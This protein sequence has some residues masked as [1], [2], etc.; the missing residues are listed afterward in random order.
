MRKACWWKYLSMIM[1]MVLMISMM[2]VQGVFAS[3]EGQGKTV[4]SSFDEMPVLE[5]TSFAQGTK[6]EDLGLPKEVTAYDEAGTSI[7][8]TD[9]VWK[10][11]AKSDETNSDVKAE[12]YSESLP[13]G[14]YVFLL[15]LGK[16]YKLADGVE[17]P[18]FYI[19]ITEPE[20]E[21]A[22]TAPETAETT[23]ETAETAPETAE[24]TP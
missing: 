18:K 5:N 15:S 6:E 14:E 9:V 8:L 23:P 3:E 10:V 12:K 22:E 1:T 17:R 21:T 11:K 2:P 7:T 19:T 24:T 20:T 16:G 4:I 13:A